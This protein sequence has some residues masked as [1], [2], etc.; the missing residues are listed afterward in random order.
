MYAF[1]AAKRTAYAVLCLCL[2][3]SLSTAIAG[4][5]SGYLGV[6]L[7]DISPS[8]AKAL[9]LESGSGVMINDVVDDSP[10]AK[11]GLESGD[12]VLS[13]NGQAVANSKEFSKAVAKV[14]P[15]QEV[16]MTVLH[17]GKNQT[18]SVEL[19][20]REDSLVWTTKKG[21]GKV[22]M[23][24]GDDN[25]EIHLKMIEE[26]HDEDLD[27]IH[28][29]VLRNH[30]G[31][32]DNEHEIIIQKMMHGDELD[33]SFFSA[34]DRGFMGVSLDDI[35]GQMA[36]FYEVE[37]GKGALITK[38]SEDSPAAEAGLMA[39]DVIIKLGDQD[40]TSTKSLHKAMQETKPEQ[41]VEVKIVR[42]GDKQTKKLTLG[43]LPEKLA[44]K[45]IMIHED[46]GQFTVRA[47]KML[48]HGKSHHGSNKDVEWVFEENELDDLREELEQMK[49]EL[50][51]MQKELK[52]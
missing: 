50:K 2:V 49:K 44:M 12:V 32:M 41:E 18:L 37:D 48:F 30:H 5:K 31:E 25:E 11:V 46:N 4:E 17:N 40:V 21:D 1:S 19:G 3:F 7:Q 34:P 15:G 47:P 23:F 36:E 42:K 45:N 28:I 6:M 29:E 13:F 8:M 39:G 14:Q 24:K 52:K 38:V 35:E 9:Q 22:F 51:E 33:M 26:L 20:E 10:A 27:D 16:Q 43:E